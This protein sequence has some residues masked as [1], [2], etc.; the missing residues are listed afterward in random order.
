MPKITWFL[1][2]L[3][4][5]QM[6]QITLRQLPSKNSICTTR[7][8][9]LRI[10]DINLQH[11]AGFTPFT[12]ASGVFKAQKLHDMKH[13]TCSQT[14]LPTHTDNS[15]PTYQPD[16]KNF[17]F[18]FSIFLLR[19]VSWMPQEEVEEKITLK[20]FMSSLEN[21]SECLE[22]IRSASSLRKWCMRLLSPNDTWLIRLNECFD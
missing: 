4:V 2:F 20:T 14:Q 21:E 15:P 18:R 17:I 19:N 13:S 7:R 10:R 11:S 16:S 5:P 9:K 8:W 22:T 1:N 3:F 6:C 12:P